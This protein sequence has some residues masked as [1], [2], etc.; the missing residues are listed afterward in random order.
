MNGVTGR[1]GTNQHLIR[2]ILALRE[3]GG[4]ALASGERLLPEPLLVGRDAGKLQ[5]LAD[6][7]GIRDWSTDLD[8]VLGDPR[9]PVYFDAQITGAREAAVRGALEAG[10]HVYCEKPLSSDLASAIDLMRLAERSPGKNGIVQDKLFLPGLLKLRRLVD[11]G[12]FG[13]LLGVRIDFG[14]WV[15]EGDWQ[16]AQRPSWNYRAEEGGG[17]IQDMFCHWRYVL[18]NLFGPVRSVSCLGTTHIAERVDERGQ[19]YPGTADDAA[20]ATLLLEGDVV[21]HVA[22]SWAT[23]VYRDDLLQI[24][25]DGTEGSAVA[26]LR[27]CKLQHRGATPRAVWN[28][29]VPQTHDFHADWVEVPDN[30]IFENAFLIQMFNGEIQ[31][32]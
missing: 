15:F 18:D 22:S 10:K 5:A 16:P 13:R 1:M 25:V 7:H 32:V 2:S 31:D 27:R 9:Y 19:P 21:A 6:A 26:G 23:R 28:P 17:I 30:G 29:D 14:Y 20:Y 4:V 11:G 8:A 3:R 12:F 24:H